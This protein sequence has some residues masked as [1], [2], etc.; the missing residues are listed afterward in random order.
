[1]ARTANEKMTKAKELYLQGHLLIEISNKLGVPEGTVRSWKNRYKWEG[2][3]NA[4]LQKKKK[5]NV[6]KKGGQPN[7]KN[8]T[9]PPE[10]KNAE[11]H[12][13]FSKYLPAETLEIVEAADRLSPLD[14]LWHQI[15]IQYAAIIRSQKIMHVRDSKDRTTNKV[16]FTDGMESTSEKWEVQEA[17]DKQANYL[18]AQARAMTSLNGMIKN[19]DEL[20]HKN[21]D[22]ATEEQR[23]RIDN[24]KASTAKLKGDDPDEGKE[25][26]GFMDA[27][28]GESGIWQE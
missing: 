25:D 11:K 22:M 16:G 8:A 1:M 3:S 6:A 14:V 4:T 10:N 2:E 17:W 9:G 7:N 5:C 27:L 12:G 13:L 19:Y 21:W 26:D 15:T 24:I 28:K 18:Q 20:L 23:A